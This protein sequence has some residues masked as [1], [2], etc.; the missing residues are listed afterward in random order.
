MPGIDI[1]RSLLQ[2]ASVQGSRSTVLNPLGWALAIVLAA[3]VGCLRWNTPVWLTIVLASSSCVTLIIY[4]F[5]YLYFVFTN[6]DALRSE[7]FTLSKM[8]IERSITGDSLKG[9]VRL[10]SDVTD[11]LPA[12]VEPTAEKPAL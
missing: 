10:G 7:K 9:F 6:S 8:A 4:L 1:V 2:Q 5:T 11:A 3:L 12:A